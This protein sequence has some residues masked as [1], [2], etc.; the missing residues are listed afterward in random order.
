MTMPN[1]TMTPG[2]ARLAEANR[3]RLIKADMKHAERMRKRGWT[4]IPPR[5]ETAQ[6][7]Q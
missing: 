6:E 5:P 3:K 7:A 1:S 4:V 2:Q